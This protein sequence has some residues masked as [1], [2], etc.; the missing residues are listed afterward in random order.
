MDRVRCV[1]G[2]SYLLG[3]KMSNAK[4]GVTDGLGVSDYAF[5]S[6][7]VEIGGVMVTFKETK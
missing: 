7:S 6:M 5:R 2:G 3:H 1:L 4:V